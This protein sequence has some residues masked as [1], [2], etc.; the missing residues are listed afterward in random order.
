MHADPVDKPQKSWIVRAAPAP[1]R[2]YV[3]LM[4]LDGPIGT[5]LLL[6][7]CWWGMALASAAGHAANGAWWPDPWQMALF[8]I[9]ALVMRGAGCTI[10]D[11][12]DRDFDARVARTRSRPIPAGEIT[13]PQALLFLAAQLA[14]AF[15]ILLQFNPPTIWLGIASLALVFPYPLMKRITWWPQLFLGLTFNWGALM[16]WTAVTG[17]LAPAE[18]LPAIVLYAAGIFWTLGYDTIYAHQ[19]KADDVLIGVKSTALKLGAASRTWIAGFYAATVLGIAIAAELA[20]LSRWYLLPLAVAGLHLLWQVSRWQPDDPDDCMRM[21][22]SNRDF[23]LVV[24]VG[25]IAGGLS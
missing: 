7:P 25:L 10:N 18:M 21:F 5:W 2:P 4:R 1:A 8:G 17:R 15:L 20:G 11:I 6:L 14:L 16:G 3:R 23:G 19:D 9:G 13:V 24:L 22:K 12:L